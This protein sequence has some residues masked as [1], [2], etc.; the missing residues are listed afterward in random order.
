MT[1]FHVMPVFGSHDT[2]DMLMVLSMEQL[3]FLTQDDQHD[4]FCYMIPLALVLALHDDTGIKEWHPYN[5]YIKPIEMRC[6]MTFCQCNAIG[7]GTS[8]T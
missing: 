1:F 7:T 8:V 5:S 6:D 4:F 3:H 2:D